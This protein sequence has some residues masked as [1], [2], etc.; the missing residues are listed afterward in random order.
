MSFE[1]ARLKEMA[2]GFPSHKPW[3]RDALKRINDL[4]IPFRKAAY[5]HPGNM[6]AIHSR[7]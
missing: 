3:I 7:K 5:Y 1:K 2:T 4:I 6:A